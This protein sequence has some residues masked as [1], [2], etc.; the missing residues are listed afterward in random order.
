MNEQE[1][2]HQHNHLWVVGLYT[3]SMGIDDCDQLQTCKAMNGYYKS[4]SF[5]YV[6]VN[7]SSALNFVIFCMIMTPTSMMYS[8]SHNALIGIC[9]RFN[10]K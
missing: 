3:M 6:N 7:G 2:T 9:L 10:P 1:W 4:V 8:M 5:G